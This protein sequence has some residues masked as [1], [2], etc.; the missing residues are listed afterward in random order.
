M[1]LVSFNVNGIRACKKKG[2][3]DF[4]KQKN[5]EILCLQEVKASRTQ[6]EIE[7][8]QDK[9]CKFGQK[10]SHLKKLLVKRSQ[11]IESLQAQMDKNKSEIGRAHV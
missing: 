1:E 8:L 11:T 10:H 2:F 6:A 7:S 4:V 5:P 9:V 3:F